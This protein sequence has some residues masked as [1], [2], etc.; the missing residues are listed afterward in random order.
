MKQ[1]LVLAVCLAAIAGSATAQPL[2]DAQIAAIVVAANR[3]DMQAGELALSVSKNPTVRRFAMRMI[4]DH[5]AAN[6]A[7]SNLV[8]RIGLT[9]RENEASRTLQDAGKRSLD[10]LRQLTGAEFDTAYL[11]HEVT[12]HV[13]V[14]ATMDEVLIPSTK[15]P[16]LASLLRKVRPNFDTHLEHARHAQGSLD[17]GAAP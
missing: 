11:A 3:A 2:D 14:I 7:A 8:A 16:E 12:F 15:N 4:T 10:E 9:P 6:R 1:V 17:R 13:E 5:M